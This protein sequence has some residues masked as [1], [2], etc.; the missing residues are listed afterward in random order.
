[1]LS[2]ITLQWSQ[3]EKNPSLQL[4]LIFSRKLCLI[5]HEN[6]LVCYSF[7]NVPVNTVISISISLAIFLQNKELNVA[8]IH[9]TLLR[10]RFEKTC[11][12]LLFKNIIDVLQFPI[13]S[14]K[15]ISNDNRFIS[16]IA[17]LIFIILCILSPEIQYDPMGF[18]QR[19]LW[20]FKDSQMD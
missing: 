8:K 16:Q 1:M 6:K 19:K 9:C 10:Q 3:S 4:F 20:K 5:D 12:L 13:K 7:S 11:Y 15:S 18:Q 17:A 14:S 2:F